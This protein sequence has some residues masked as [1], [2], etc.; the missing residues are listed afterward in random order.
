MKKLCR[1]FVCAL[2]FLT[3]LQATHIDCAVAQEGKSA[4]ISLEFQYH[5]AD[6]G[7]ALYALVNKGN[8]SSTFKHYRMKKDHLTKIDSI[9]TLF[10]KEGQYKAMGL[11]FNKHRG[12]GMRLGFELCDKVAK[13]MDIAV[14]P[15]D[16]LASDEVRVA[17]LKRTVE[18][19][20]ETCKEFVFVPIHEKEGWYDSLMRSIA[21][22]RITQHIPYD[23]LDQG[24]QFMGMVAGTGVLTGKA[25]GLG[26]KDAKDTTISTVASAVGLAVLWGVLK[27]MSAKQNY[28]EQ[29]DKEIKDEGHKHK[30]K[31]SKDSRTLVAFF[32][33]EGPGFK[34]IEKIQDKMVIDE[35]DFYAK[36]LTQP[37]AFSRTSMAI[38]M[39][40]APGNGKGT[41]IKSLSE[42]SNT[43]VVT[44]SAQDLYYSDSFKK[45]IKGTLVLASSK[46]QKSCI[47]LFDEVDKMIEGDPKVLQ[48]LLTLLDDGVTKKNPH[49]R[50]LYVFTTNHIHKIE[51]SLIRPGRVHSRLCVGPP[52]ESQRLELI[53]LEGPRLFSDMSKEL[54]GKLANLTEGFSRA[55]ITDMLQSAYNVTICVGKE[56]QE[57]DFIYE[58]HKMKYFMKHR[59]EKTKQIM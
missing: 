35:L 57:E 6:L 16:E 7:C 21:Y 50:F 10:Y 51:E 15:M 44:I 58:I 47:I 43:P 29:Q 54:I 33:E 3:G 39:Y 1:I 28:F 40:G 49:V 11:A 59:F 17:C 45:K 36:W 52:N 24:I 4:D 8:L 9:N 5:M 13:I 27:E 22:N 46:K 12:A 42:E 18:A 19:I 56:F 14:T 55:A 25:I 38:F 34:N 32:G 26:N 2:T 48:N 23:H 31:E 20:K 30:K 53:E 37:I 41:M